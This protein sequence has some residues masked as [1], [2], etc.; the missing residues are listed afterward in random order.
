MGH[1]L[2]TRE[3]F[4]HIG[5]YLLGAILMDQNRTGRLVHGP[6]ACCIALQRRLNKIYYR[7]NI[8]G[9]ISDQTYFKK[10]LFFC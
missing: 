6:I 8:V 4:L 10:N 7:T 1:Q 9:L 3:Y 5:M 2:H